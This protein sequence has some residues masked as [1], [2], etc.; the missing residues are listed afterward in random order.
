MQLCSRTVITQ[1]SIL[2]QLSRTKSDFSKFYIPICVPGEI[3]E[4][5]VAHEYRYSYYGEH[6]MV[7]ENLHI[8]AFDV[9]LSICL[10]D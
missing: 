5:C 3:V 4:T 7:T 10:Q 9:E 1:T 2:V 6:F 8:V